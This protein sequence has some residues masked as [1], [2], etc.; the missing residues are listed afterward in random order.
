M[1]C[2]GMFPV[3]SMAHHKHMRFR[4]G[5]A[6]I[7]PIACRV[8]FETNRSKLKLHMVSCYI[9]I[10]AA[11]SYCM[12]WTGFSPIVPDVQSCL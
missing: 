4:R 11:T 8:I 5:D 9:N 6:C 10:L 1:R 3:K 12:L 2:E 7:H